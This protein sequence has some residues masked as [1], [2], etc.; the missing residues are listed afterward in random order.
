MDR[1]LLLEIGLS[2]FS[3]VPW[4]VFLLIDNIYGRK[5]LIFTKYNLCILSFIGHSF[6][7]VS[8]KPLANPKA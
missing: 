4:V 1:S 5:C 8:K 3:P 6:G 7:V 2:R